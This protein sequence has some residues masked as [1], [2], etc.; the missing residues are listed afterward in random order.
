MTKLTVHRKGYSR[1]AFA[2]KSGVH[3]KASHVG[4]ST[5]R[6][7]DRGAKGRGTKLF[8]LK[9]GTLGVHFKQGTATRHRRE[10]TLAHKYGEKKIVGK[11]RALQV[12]NKRTN[13]TMA[14]KAKADAHYIAG[15]FRGRKLV[16]YP[17]GFSRDYKVHAQAARGQK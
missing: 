16:K 13:P 11:L 7:K 4:K 1:H 5:F 17:T 8:H 2:R 3:V 15:S 6:I 9:K 12:L 10:A 14:R